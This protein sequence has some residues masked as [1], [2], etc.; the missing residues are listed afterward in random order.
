MNKYYYSN[1]MFQYARYKLNA[2][3]ALKLTKSAN[4]ESSVRSA[5]ATKK[6]SFVVVEGFIISWPAGFHTPRTNRVMGV[7]N[8]DPLP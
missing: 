6:Q 2:D 3:D 7:M 8:P 1:I 5:K 4:F